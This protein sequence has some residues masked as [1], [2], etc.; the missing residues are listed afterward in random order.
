MQAKIQLSDH[1]TI[2]KLLRFTFP[3]IGMMVFVS[4][5]GIV[6][7]LFVS[8][9]VGQTPFAAV[10]FIWP[11]ILILMAVGFMFGAGGS[12][13]ISKLLGENDKERAN[14]VFSLIIYSSIAFGVVLA[15]IAYLALPSIAELLGATGELLDNS[16]TYGR[17]IVLSLPL[18]IVMAEAQNL[19]VTAEKPRLG[20]AITVAAGMTNIVLDAIFIAGF[21]MKIEGAA[22]ATAISNAVGGIAA[23]CYFLSPNKSLLRIGKPTWE[24]KP[25]LKTMGNGSS[26]LLSNVAMSLVGMLYNYQLLQYAGENGVSA[27]GIILYVNYIFISVFIGYSIGIAPVVSY[28]YGAKNNEEIKSLLKK[29]LCMVF[30]SSIVM[31]VVAESLSTPLAMI[32]TSDQTLLDMTVRGFYIYSISFLLA[33]YPIIASSFFTALN[34]GLVSALISFSRTIVFQIIAIMIFPLIWELDGIWVSIVMAEMC[35]V[36]VAFIALWLGRKKYGYR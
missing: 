34:N 35:S 5:Y 21:G 32:F 13:I 12:A 18:Y 17:I 28:H 1:F 8:N 11:Y 26:E 23:L 22:I 4:I 27:Y 10:N 6:D 7:G 25:L 16:I 36:A 20:L 30:V 2:K 14:K 33:G 19:F 3:S 31:F 9:M 24:I 15:G 29:S